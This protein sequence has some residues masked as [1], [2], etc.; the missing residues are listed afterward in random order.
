M[1][2][3]KIPLVW[4]NPE[5]QEINRLPMRSPLLPFASPRAALA[6][7]IAGPEFRNLKKNNFFLSLDGKWQFNLLDNPSDDGCNEDGN[8]GITPPEWTAPEFDASSWPLIQVPG[9]WTRQGYDKPHYTNV[10]MPF[11]ETPPHAPK[12]N[13]TGCYRLDF[14]VPASWKDRRVVLWVGSAESVSL[15]YVNGAFAGAGKDTRLPSE[16]DITSF[17]RKGKNLLCIKVIRYSDASHVE[18]Q[19]QWWFGGIHRSMFLYSTEERY[20]AEIK[21][22]PGTLEEEGR[23]GIL[24]ISVTLGGKLPASRSHG[25]GQVFKPSKEGPFI[26]KYAVYPFSLPAG[27]AA[28]EKQAAAA[29]ALVSGEIK[30]D[31]DYR[32]NSNTAETTIQVP[33]PVPWSHEAP[34]LYVLR[35][36]VYHQGRH[37]ESAAFCTGFRNVKIANRELLINGKAVYIKGVNRHEHDEKTGKTLSTDSMVKDIKLMKQYNFNAVRTSH[38]PND[39]RWYEL[40]DRYGIYVTDEANIENH[41]FYDQLCEDPAYSYAYL[42]RMQRMV[43][44]DKNHP[45]VTV[46]SLGNESGDG[47]SHVMGSAWIHRYDPTRLVHYEGAIR[48]KMKEGRTRSDVESMRRNR[49]VTD[50][51]CPFYLPLETII[52]FSKN[53]NDPRPLIFAEYSHAM[54][55][56]SGTLEDYWKLIE[57][58][59]G[60]QGGH[61]WE[62]MDH[63]LEA[64]NAD[65]KKYWKYGGNFGDLPTDYDF[66]LDGLLLADRTVKPGMTECKQVFS[67]LR[68]HPIPEKPYSFI[69]ENRLDFSTPENMELRWK[70]CTEDRVLKEVKTPLPNLAPG[71]SAEISFPMPPFDPGL[72][73]GALFIH[74]DFLLKKNTPWAKAGH[75]I[76]S[77]E[78]ILR[79][80][81]KIPVSSSLSQKELMSFAELWKPSLFRVPTQNDGLKTVLDQRNIPGSIAYKRESALYAW[82]DMDLMHMR[83][84]EEKKKETHWQG[85]PAVRYTATLYTGEKA[86][87]RYRDIRLGCYTCTIVKSGEKLP[88]IMDIHFELDPSLPELPRVGITANIPACYGDISW[89]GRGPDE[90]YSDRKAAAFLGRY[91]HSVAELEIPYAVPQENGNRTGLR[92][93]TLGGEKIPAGKPPA[94]SIQPE[95]PM[96][97]SVSRYTRENM[98]AALHTCDLVD[99]SVGEK[100]YYILN[101]DIAQRGLGTATCGPDTREEYRVRPGSF[102]MK[103][104]IY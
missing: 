34:N 4:E 81:P 94:Y 73:D 41:C 102:G 18:D 48:R 70:L 86:V 59:P 7:A 64:F 66:C 80:E 20:I 33:N 47:A 82:V 95:G 69:L 3:N 87:P 71:S 12:D 92:A 52:D 28:A 8:G 79:E 44:R 98:M 6:D 62:W 38:Y 99:V 24:D 19:D 60:L 50:I 51:V 100:G 67:P 10:Q 54:G 36:S 77:A 75:I 29:K 22:L 46:W 39:E 9:T 13:P 49:N 65:G 78:R 40:C 104:Y 88:L 53:G 58:Y 35:L 91:N 11:R 90:N 55:N 84:L 83:T 31:C 103:L 26:I 1:S 14:S 63:G 74:A 56:S 93:I 27:Y 21:A 61:I 85:L 96:N 2:N 30:L 15:V 76:G 97:F 42:S 43:I 32:I 101:I 57:S 23:K 37:I 25:P 16:Y 72:Q 5:I 68:L 89:F 45:A 17:L